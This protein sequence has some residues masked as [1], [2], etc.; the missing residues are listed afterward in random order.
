MPSQRKVKFIDQS[1]YVMSWLD[2]S[3][4]RMRYLKGLGRIPARR[5]E[6]C[7]MSEGKRDRDAKMQR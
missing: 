1:S 6:E 5:K 2:D 3:C 4:Q 7:K